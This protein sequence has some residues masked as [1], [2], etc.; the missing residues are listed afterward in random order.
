MIIPVSRPPVLSLLLNIIKYLYFT[1]YRQAEKQDN[2]EDEVIN[3]NNNH[4]KSMYFN[5]ICL[6]INF[7]KLQ[8]TK[9]NARLVKPHSLLQM[10]RGYRLVKSGT[11][12]FFG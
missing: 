1:K 8:S 9:R 7:L 10:L 5:L 6:F 11:L 4:V 12:I 3:T 2:D